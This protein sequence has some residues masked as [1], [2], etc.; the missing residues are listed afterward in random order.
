M[1]RLTKLM[2]ILMAGLFAGGAMAQSFPD[3]GIW[4]YYTTKDE[5]TDRIAHRLVIDAEKISAMSGNI[6]MHI[7]CKDNET[8]FTIIVENPT[9]ATTYEGEYRWKTDYRIDKLQANK[10]ETF[11]TKSALWS[12]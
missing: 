1:L 7:T 10:F 6:S 5:F 2:I 4:D 12:L 11:S 3:P 8:T 9:L